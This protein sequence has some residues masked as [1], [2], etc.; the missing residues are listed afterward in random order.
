[1]DLN[2]KYKVDNE[3]IV[4]KYAEKIQPYSINDDMNVVMIVDFKYIHN[5]DTNEN[6]II[7]VGSTY[8]NLNGEYEGIWSGSKFNKYIEPEEIRISTTGQI[9]VE[10]KNK[11][12]DISG[13]Q[14]VMEIENSLKYASEIETYAMTINIKE[15]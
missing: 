12:T 11:K 2:S 3:N 7:S 10:V 13:L 1:M 5:K 9:L 8:I 4:I 14:K 6:K 15:L